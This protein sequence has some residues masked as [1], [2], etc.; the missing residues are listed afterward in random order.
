MAMQQL[1]VAS[2]TMW[3]LHSF[4]LEDIVLWATTAFGYGLRRTSSLETQLIDSE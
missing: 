1:H 4:D 3:T 2:G